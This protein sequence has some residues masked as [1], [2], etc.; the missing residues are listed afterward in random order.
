MDTARDTAR[1][2]ARDTAKDTDNDAA[3]AVLVMIYIRPRE[4]VRITRRAWPS[5]R[6]EAAKRQ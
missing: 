4:T 6:E 3:R 2:R 5:D 1:D